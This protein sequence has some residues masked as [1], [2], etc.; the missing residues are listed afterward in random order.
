[1]LKQDGGLPWAS[2]FPR[3]AE[4]QAQ[5]AA[6]AELLEKER[7]YAS[8]GERVQAM[9]AALIALVSHSR[10]KD[11]IIQDLLSHLD[12][13]DQLM[14]LFSVEKREELHAVL[15]QYKQPERHGDALTRFVEQM[16]E[17]A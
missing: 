11:A 8:P 2:V 17:F 16:G 13:M 4:I 7:Q 9:Q 10:A 6:M 5:E 3:I 14:S 1:M 12:L 15:A